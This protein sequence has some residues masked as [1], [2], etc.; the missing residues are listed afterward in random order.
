MLGHRKTRRF[1]EDQ[2]QRKPQLYSPRG[3]PY[4]LAIS[5]S[6]N[7]DERASMTERYIRWYTQWL[8]REF[9]MIVFGSGEGLPFVL[10]T[11]YGRRYQNNDFWR[12]ILPYCLSAL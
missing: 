1:V 5:P 4:G 11:S 12:D 3:F 6:R 7:Q 10:P 2:T 9:E 8:S